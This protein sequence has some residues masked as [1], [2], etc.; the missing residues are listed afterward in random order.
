M[1]VPTIDLRVVH[2]VRDPRASAFSWRS[3]K[4]GFTSHGVVESAK[5]WTA[6]NAMLALLGSRLDDHYLRV[7]YEDFV[8][9]PRST[10]AEISRF[11]GA[12]RSGFGF[13]D[14]ENIDIGTNHFVFGNPDL[15]RTGP[16]RLKLDERWKDD[17]AGRERR[18]VTSLSWPLMLRFGYPLGR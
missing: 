4:E 7:R 11:A 16:I 15:F 3:S 8:T 17:M 1:Q 6:R 10:L 2:I 18:L 14:G 5:S 12:E 9:D 13:L